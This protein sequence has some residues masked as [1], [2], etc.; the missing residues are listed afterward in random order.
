MIE[1]LN[2]ITDTYG[3]C[4][5]MAVRAALGW[6]AENTVNWDAA[7]DSPKGQFDT[8]RTHHEPLET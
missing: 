1:V 6:E 7:I 8:G 5:A 4:T 2:A 3:Q